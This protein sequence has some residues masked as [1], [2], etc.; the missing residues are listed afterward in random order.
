VPAVFDQIGVSLECEG[1]YHDLG[2]F[3]NRI[4]SRMERL[5]SVKDFSIRGHQGGSVPGSR[6]LAIN[7]KLETY[8]YKAAAAAPG[9][10]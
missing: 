5:V 6:K 3:I 7:L 8:C 10:P 2:Q 9:A 1:G 4:E